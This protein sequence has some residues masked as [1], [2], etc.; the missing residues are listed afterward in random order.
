MFDVAFVDGLRFWVA[1]DRKTGLR[2]LEIVEAIQR[3]P[4]HGIGKPE[5]LKHLVSGAWSRR[6]TLEHRIG[7]RIDGNRIYFLQ[8]RY[9]Y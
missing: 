3:D 7:H 1:T 4:F 6:L 9:H 8:A 5:P 2:V